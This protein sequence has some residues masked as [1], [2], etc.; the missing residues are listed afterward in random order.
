MLRSSTHSLQVQ[1]YAVVHS[2]P[3][4]CDPAQQQVGQFCWQVDR[5]CHVSLHLETRCAGRTQKRSP[6]QR[7]ASNARERHSV[8]QFECRAEGANLH[9]ASSRLTLAPPVLGARLRPRIGASR[10]LRCQ[11][12]QPRGSN[13]RWS[14]TAFHM[15]S[16]SRIRLAHRW[17]RDHGRARGRCASVRRGARSC[18]SRAENVIWHG[19]AC[20]CRAVNTSAGCAGQKQVINGK[21]SYLRAV[22]KAVTLHSAQIYADLK[23]LSL[24]L[25]GW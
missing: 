5:L 11:R 17:S 14:T 15:G 9:R 13:H 22:W 6:R 2:S 20:N 10:A 8:S 21:G 1:A 25:D 19:C 23:P 4:H 7:T 3:Y 12:I 16:T 18:S 24:H